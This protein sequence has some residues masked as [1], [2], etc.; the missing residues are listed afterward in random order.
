MTTVVM[1][2]IQNFVAACFIVPL[3]TLMMPHVVRSDVFN[4]FSYS[5][6]DVQHGSSGDFDTW[7]II[8]RDAEPRSDNT[9]TNKLQ[10]GFDVRR[11]TNQFVHYR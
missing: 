5:R 1:L 10:F 11:G 4:E 3:L 6:I 7:R 8:F 9:E 2:K